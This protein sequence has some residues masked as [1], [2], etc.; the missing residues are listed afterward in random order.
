MS[1]PAQIAS[2]VARIGDIA[3][4]YATAGEGR[5]VVF[6]HGLAESR[7]SW[8]AQQI[9]L[10]GV[11]TLAYDLR[12]HG[13]TTTGDADGSLAQLGGDLV[14]L[15]EALTGPAT[16]VGFSLGGTVV[17]WAAAHAPELVERAIVLGTSSVVGRSAAAFYEERIALAR[18]G[19][20]AAFAAALRADT[21]AALARDDVDVDA[22]TAAR[23]AA[24]GDGEG[25]VNAARA[26]ARMREEPLTPLLAAVRCHVDVVGGERDAFCPRKAADIV[27]E[28]LP[29]AAY[30]EL[31]G[32]GHLMNVED[33]DAV[34]ALLASLIDKE[35]S[36]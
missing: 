21:R 16:C 17:L 19:D 30:H 14:R 10:G 36:A 34:T 24:V 2:G 32:L 18:S 27:V 12:G 11:Q 1:R 28:A 33:P 8:A 35:K 29:D 31:P 4:A 9:A 23:L 22:L 26:M 3:V 6:V 13:E 7:A 20:R 15:L 5:P 25:Y